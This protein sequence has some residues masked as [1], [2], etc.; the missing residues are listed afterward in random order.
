MM[1]LNTDSVP[2]ISREYMQ[3]LSSYRRFVH[4]FLLYGQYMMGKSLCTVFF[5]DKTARSCSDHT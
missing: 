3:D 4:N 1:W 2:L 5:Q